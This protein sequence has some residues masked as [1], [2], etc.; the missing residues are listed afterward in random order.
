MAFQNFGFEDE[1]V[2][3]LGL[4]DIWT[5]AITSTGFEQAGFDDGSVV[6]AGPTPLEKFEG[7]WN[8]NE[9]YLFEFADPIDPLELEQAIY[10]P[11]DPE[12]VE[13]FEEFWDSNE[14]Y[15]YLLASVELAQYDTTLDQFEDFEEEWDSNEDFL[16]D[17]SDVIAGLGQD[18]AQ[19]DTTPEGFEDF[20]EEWNDNDNYLFGWGE[21]VLGPGQ[22]IASYD[23]G[24]TP[25]NFEDF[26]EV[27]AP[28]DFT[29]VVATS[30]LVKNLHGLSNNEIVTLDNTGGELPAGLNIGYEYYVINITPNDFQLSTS[31]GGAAIAFTTTGVG[32]H[33]L[34]PDPSKFWVDVM[35]TI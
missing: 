6:V 8:S 14:N 13:D 25:E 32:T 5:V 9:D 30:R 2:T 1:D 15:L 26:E 21:V 23:S 7:G 34:T 11:S 35:S 29:A 17:W 4:P 28:F 22:V 33:T 3:A 18:I 10:D 20:E 24:G 27:L 19:Y 31:L 16:F 12:S